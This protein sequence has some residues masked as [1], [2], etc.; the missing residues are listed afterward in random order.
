MVD[1]VPA[2]RLYR[3]CDPAALGFATT[4]E[5]ADLDRVIGQDRAMAA[6]DFGTGIR[7]DGYNLFCLGPSGLGRHTL[8][9]HLLERKGRGAPVPPDWCYIH[10]F[11]RPHEPRSLRLPAGRGA[12]LRDAMNALIDELQAAI[13]ATLESEGFRR[14]RETIEEAAKKRGEEAFS[15]LQEE[16]EGRGVGLVRTPVGMI[17]A[18][19]RDGRP[20]E[21][22]AFH[23]LPEEEQA[24]TR[25]AIE[26]LQGKLEAILREIP[27]WSR[28]ARRE[29]EALV[30]DSVGFAVGQLVEDA[31]RPF[32]DLPAVLAH[33]D[34]VRADVIENVS[35]SL[36][37]GETGGEAPAVGVA[38]MRERGGRDDLGPALDRYRVN[39]LVDNADTRGAP[40]VTEDHPTYENLIGRAEHVQRMGVLSTDFTLIKPGALHR[41]NGG[42]L[43]LDARR[44]LMQPFAWEALKRALRARQIRLESLGQ[45]VGLIATVSLEPEPI[46]LDVRI[47]LVGER[48]LYYL[49]A[50]YDPDFQ[51]LFKVPVDFAEE[52]G[53]ADASVGDFARLVATLARRE[54]LRPLDAGAVARIV[55][56]AARVAEDA[57]KLSLHRRALT[58]LLR[59]ADYW[60]GQ[61]GA[62]A[63]GADHVQQALDTGIHRA[64]RVRERIQEM[65]RRGTIMIDTTGAA[66]GRI[67]GLAV[68]RLGAFSFA[69]PSRITARTRLGSGKVVDIEREAE[70]GGP[71]HSKGVLILQG[72]LAARYA[73]DKPLALGA[74]LVF[75]Q[76]YGGVD[77]DSASSA[78]LYALLSALADAP[79]RQGVAV[80]G[81]VNQQGEVQA[82]GGVNEKIEGFFDVCAAGGLTGDQ[83][84]MIP[85]TNLPHLMLR[86]DVVEAVR[87]GRF[88]V[89]AVRTIDEGIALLTGL[90]AGERVA[91]GAF[92]EGTINRR[93]DD[94]LA[95]FAEAARAFARP[96]REVGREEGAS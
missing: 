94:R 28:E 63:I 76:S 46:P 65:I 35:A 49:L 6:L 47:V 54:S 96:P 64:D 70:T 10:N 43:V 51:D 85:A 67:N 60:T 59:E 3:R 56:H 23:A 24:T 29:M 88:A 50:E 58:D 74:S 42:Y 91:D 73:L 79:I 41:A 66:V 90:P 15:A 38:L 77:G 72:F 93:V 31:G 53:R 25:A 40:V 5:L 92:P 18:P 82:I 81:S 57:E 48:A 80:T 37:A 78:E 2:D 12:A 95:A 36:E 32:A 13:R 83:G 61:A 44:V 19:I 8:T 21:P 89:W 7:H 30:R 27:R 1:P 52:M 62:A 34:A 4:E 55:E 75:E 22:D 17:I 84:V 71:L 39:L 9:L 20:M 87:A 33:L 45:M 68:S 69:R 16:A 11:D 26:E 14:R 86:A